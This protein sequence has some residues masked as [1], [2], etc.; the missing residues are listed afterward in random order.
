MLLLDAKIKILDC[1]RTVCN[2]SFRWDHKPSPGSEWDHSVNLW[3]ITGGNGTLR[4]GER[5]Y[6]LTAGDCFFLPMASPRLA[7]Q[8]LPDP[9]LVTWIIF[10]MRT[11][12]NIP[13]LPNS[14]L[15]PLFRHFEDLTLLQSLT[16]RFFE[17]VTVH[18]KTSADAT[19]WLRA[20]LQEILRHD[21]LHAASDSDAILEE[22][23]QEIRNSPA[24]EHNIADLAT[25]MNCSVDHFIRLFSARFGM[26]PGQ[27]IIQARIDSAK[28]SLLYSSMSIK[29]IAENLGY[30]NPFFFSKQFKKVTGVRPSQFREEHN[31]SRQP[32]KPDMPN[33]IP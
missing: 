12:E 29:E 26:T 20:I 30:C 16:D 31:N 23:R 28:N 6:S 18:R 4:E 8:T 11:L 7:F 3:L 25:R 1:D 10:E 22:I 21:R 17:A 5:D 9:M 2:S 15:L 27:Y 19:H 24:S 32:G 33:S 13:L 14:T